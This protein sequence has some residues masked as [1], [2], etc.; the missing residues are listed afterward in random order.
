[1]LRPLLV[2]LN[3][4]LDFMDF[5]VEEVI[6]RFF[7]EHVLFQGQVVLLEHRVVGVE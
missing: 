7:T 5:F 4:F 2:V 3:L 1:M 6:L